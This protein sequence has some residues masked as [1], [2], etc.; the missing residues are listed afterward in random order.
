MKDQVKAVMIKGLASNKEQDDFEALGTLL[1]T[2]MINPI[3]DGVITPDGAALIL[4]GQEVDFGL[5]KK[6]VLLSKAGTVAY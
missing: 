2:A 4:Q 1:A 6:S 3:I 5:N